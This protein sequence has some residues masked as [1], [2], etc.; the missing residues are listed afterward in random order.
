MYHLGEMKSI[1]KTKYFLNFMLLYV[2][3]GL[4]PIIYKSVF[5]KQCYLVGKFPDF[6]FDIPGAFV[7]FRECDSRGGN[8]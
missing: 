4:L 2:V 8:A 6:L 3:L 7:D 1:K 5:P